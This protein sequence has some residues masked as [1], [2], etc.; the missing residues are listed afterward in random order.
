MA[1]RWQLGLQE[2]HTTDAPDRTKADHE[3][4]AADVLDIWKSQYPLPTED[5]SGSL[6][7]IKQLYRCAACAELS[8]CIAATA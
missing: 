5:T 7:E 4:K 2:L 3:G 8:C 1:V 6:N